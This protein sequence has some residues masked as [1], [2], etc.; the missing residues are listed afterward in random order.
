MGERGRDVRGCGTRDLAGATGCEARRR[1][2][3]VPANAALEVLVRMPVAQVAMRVL[4]PVVL[5]LPETA[6]KEASAGCPE[7]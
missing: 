3:D 7:V 1:P 2:E 6:G 5:L 4:V